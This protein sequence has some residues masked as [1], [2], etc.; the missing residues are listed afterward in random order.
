MK[1]KLEKLRQEI[2]AK[3]DPDF[4]FGVEHWDNGNYD[5]SY[6]YGVEVGEEYAYRDLLTK[7]DAI[8]KEI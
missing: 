7:I 1:E 5:D 4:D 3:V 2:E 6:E 8:L